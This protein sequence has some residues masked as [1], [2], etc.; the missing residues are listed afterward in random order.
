MA[1]VAQGE[2]P[3]GLRPP[4]RRTHPDARRNRRRTPL[5]P[6]R[7]RRDGRDAGRPL[8]HRPRRRRRARPRRRRALAAGAASHV[9]AQVAF[10]LV[11]AAVLIRRGPALGLLAGATAF[12]ALSLVVAPIPP[13]FAILAGVPALLLGTALMK[14][15]DPST[16]R[17]HKNPCSEGNRIVQGS[18]PGGGA[19]GGGRV[20]DGGRVAGDRGPGRPGRRGDDRGVPRAEHGA[21]VGALPQPRRRGRGGCPAR[22]RGRAALAF[23]PARSLFRAVGSVSVDRDRPVQDDRQVPRARGGD[24]GLRGTAA[25]SPA[26]AESP[27]P[28]GRLCDV[29]AGR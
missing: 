12:V 28:A 7:R 9:V 13:L 15:S 2:S 6:R 3:H 23:R 26:D 21:G 27:G 16:L 19:R 29:L 8:D 4:P 10:A 24:A 22:A 11:F 25:V 18:D 14:G 20:R 1:R 17:S 5:R